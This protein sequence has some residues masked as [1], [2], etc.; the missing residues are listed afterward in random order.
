MLFHRKASAQ[1]A[2]DVKSGGWERRHLACTGAAGILPARGVATIDLAGPRAGRT[3]ALPG[4]LKLHGR[5]LTGGRAG[6]EI[7]TRIEAHES[8]DEIG[9]E[10]AQRLVVHLDRLVVTPALD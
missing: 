9:R 4:A 8:C 3:P 5:R 6:F 10:S 2:G 7:R 1:V